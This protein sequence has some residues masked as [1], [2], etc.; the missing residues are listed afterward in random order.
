M[1]EEEGQSGV[2][3]TGTPRTTF[4]GPV[5]SVPTGQVVVLGPYM[6]LLSVAR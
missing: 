2:G 5:R 6:V 4:F 3:G 1:Q